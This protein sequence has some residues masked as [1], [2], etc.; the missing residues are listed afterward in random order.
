MTPE[1]AKILLKT[2]E[3]EKNIRL[4]IAKIDGKIAII[5]M[6]RK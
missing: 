2:L 4:A 1:K 3:I 6:S 5:E